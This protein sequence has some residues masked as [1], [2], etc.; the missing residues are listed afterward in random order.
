[1]TKAGSLAWVIGEVVAAGADGSPLIERVCAACVAMLPVDGASISV[2]TSAGGPTV[3]ATDLVASRLADLQYATGEGPGA[4]AD[5]ERRP[6][7]VPDLRTAGAESW[8]AFAP[9]AAETGAGSVCAFPLQLGAVRLGVLETYAVAPG[10][11]AGADLD[12]AL[13]LADA[14]TLT[15]LQSPVDGDDAQVRELVAG[16]AVVHQA[17]GML[18][19]QLGVDIETAFVALRAHAFSTDRSVRDVA[20]NVVARRLRLSVGEGPFR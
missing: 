15:L 13:T 8:P 14:A 4:D 5:R 9:T 18:V 20:R 1:M 16:H 2:R 19:V 17:A 3:H 6:V 10:C 7:L 11:L 12:L